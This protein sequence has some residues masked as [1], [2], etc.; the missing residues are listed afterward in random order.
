MEKSVDLSIGAINHQEILLDDLF[1]NDWRD[2]SINQL[3]LEVDREKHERFILREQLA[4]LQEDNDALQQKN[5]KWVTKLDEE[6]E[7]NAKAY[8]ELSKKHKTEFDL[9]LKVEFRLK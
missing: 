3:K 9:R 1:K 7:K 4:A 8:E 5:K 2:E 6:I